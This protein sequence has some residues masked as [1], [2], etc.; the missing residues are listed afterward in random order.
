MLKHRCR[1]LSMS[2]ESEDGVPVIGWDYVR[3]ASAQPAE[4]RCFLDLNFI[5]RGK[6]P[7]W[8]AEA[9]RPAD[10][11]GVF[12]AMGDIPLRSGN[13][14]EMTRG[15]EGTFVAE[16]AFDEAWTP[17]ARHHIEIGVLEVA[18]QIARVQYR[19]QP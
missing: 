16:G 1:V 17:S 9:G 8:T 2:E 7:Q 6:D 5:R 12:F 11:S 13:R 14:I 3:D 15:P 19:Q 4:F 10:R 18:S